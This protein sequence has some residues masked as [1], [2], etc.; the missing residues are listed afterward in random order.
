MASA[1]GESESKRM[2]EQDEMGDDDNCVYENPLTRRYA[3]KEMSWIW[4]SR[5]KF[6]TW[7]KL[8]IALAKSEMA[9]GLKEINQE[10]ID[11][12]VENINTID[13]AYAEAKEKELRHDVMSHV[14]AY[15]KECPKAMPIIHLGATSC[16]VTDNTEII[17]MKR[18]MELIM[19]KLVVLISQL[20]QF[21]A[22]YKNVPTLGFTHFQPAQLVTVGKRASLW[23]QDFLLDAERLEREIKTLPLRGVK[24]T[25]GTQASFLELFNG[26]HSKVIE[27]D[28]LVVKEM[29]FDSS[30]PL[31]SQTYT[32]KLDYFV[33]SVLS[34]IAQSAHKMATDIRLLANAKEI[35]EP[36]EKSQIGSSAMAY[37]RNP[38]R[39][40]RIC[41]LA[42]YVISLTDNAAYTHSLQWLER[43]LDDSANRRLILPEAF[44][45]ID[46]ILIIA[47]NVTNGMQVYPNV[48][49][50]RIEAELPFMST[51]IILMEC[52]KKGGDRQQIHEAI[53]EHSME[54]AKR[55]KLEGAK[56]DLID[57]IKNDSR[58]AAV[59]GEKLDKILSPE[60]FIGRCVEQVEGFIADIVQPFLARHE[61]DKG[62]SKSFELKV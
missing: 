29:G 49:K 31:S 16:Y 15:G 61:S 54:A 44:L 13:F 52:V 38:M 25:T 45:A 42:R 60:N 43:T 20:S 39:C 30:I 3:S 36:F 32:R 28:K 53:R 55:V 6:V 47:C 51:E 37:K 22:K 5:N 10:Q 19:S 1:N 26:D 18:S 50:S 33:L 57:R 8:W 24:G 46:S 12:M 41:S 48:I 9:L 62:S 21:A 7:R 17:Q 58:F 14:H 59:H 56:N 35:E 40:E 34:G 2:K 23:M 11:S 4:S 27:L